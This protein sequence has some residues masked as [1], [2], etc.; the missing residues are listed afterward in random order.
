MDTT[1]ATEMMVIAA[2]TAMEVT[3]AMAVAG[4]V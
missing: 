4:K 1:A 2:V 3:E